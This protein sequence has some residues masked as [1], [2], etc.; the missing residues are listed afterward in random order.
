MS[1]DAQSDGLRPALPLVV[2]GFV[3]SFV[4]VGGGID[5]VSV[6]INAITQAT[7]WPR[8]GLSLGVSVGAACAALSTPAVGMAVD[9]YGVRV[10]MLAGVLFLAA[11]FVI[12][13]GM[14][15][16]WHFVAANVLLGPG[17][18]GTAM[19]PITVAVTLRVPDRTALALG[20]IG[21][22]ASI[23]ALVLAPA[24][25]AAAEAFGWRGAYAVLGSAVVLTPVPFLLFTLPRGRLPRHASSA[26]PQASLGADLRRPG[27]PALA[28]IMILPGLAGFS[29]S[30]HLVPYLTGLG[31]SGTLAAAALGGTIGISAIGKVA[32]GFIADR[33]GVLRTVRLAF[34]AWVAALA[35]LHHA[36]TTPI[37]LAFV[38]L[39]GL[40]FGT[41][42]AV[43]PAIALDI[44]GGARF[45]TLFGIMQLAA[46]LASA[47][48][49]VSS[50]IIFD[51]THSYGGALLVWGSAMVLA[52]VIA[53][54]MRP[55]TGQ[56]AAI[57]RAA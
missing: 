4:L 11:G 53:W 17:F 36:G 40:A 38:V 56:P 37:L 23:G 7:G 45:G 25:Q 31:H 16:P 26:G 19:L 34:I 10:P 24:V 1:A 51:R 32:G 3:I 55:A 15:E 27:V 5:T 50:G 49:P 22:G 33:V 35:L 47:V 28:G 44:L 29:V 54:F 2:A 39:Y 20:I 57:R 48:G 13:L 42:I 12:L 30:V 14:T 6:F 8:S 21:S 18:A 52:T 41:Q 9:R 43:I 46:M